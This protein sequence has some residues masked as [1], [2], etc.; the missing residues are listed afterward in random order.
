M[1]H[2]GLQVS[3]QH[4]AGMRK[5]RACNYATAADVCHPRQLLLQ[6]CVVQAVTSGANPV[7]IKKGIDKTCTYLV[8]KLK[9]NSRPVKG[10]DDIRVRAP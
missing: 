6:G 1:I 8:K 5:R 4:V 2:F 3:T 9:E 7:A 10:T